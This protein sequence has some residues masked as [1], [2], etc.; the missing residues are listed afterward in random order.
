MVPLPV[1]P[2]A[3]NAMFPVPEAPRP[4]AVLLLVQLYV[5]PE[6]PPK[7]IDTGAPTQALWGPGLVNAG[8]GF[9]VIVNTIAGPKQVPEAGVT[10]I[11]AV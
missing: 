11:W 8:T 7:G 4:M 2:A 1:V 3:V 9:T 6:V 5:A 10:V